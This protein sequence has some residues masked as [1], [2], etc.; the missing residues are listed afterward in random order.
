MTIA[1]PRAEHDAT[2]RL[3][4]LRARAPDWRSS[5]AAMPPGGIAVFQP[6]LHAGAARRVARALLEEA[7][8]LGG[9]QVLGFPGGDLLLG[10]HAAPGQR[11][12]QA[13]GRLL[14]Q[15][16]L[17]RPLPQ[18]VAEVSG[19]CEAAS[20]APAQ[21][22][23]SLAALEA[24]CAAW[25]LEAAARL[26][27]F[28]ESRV[29]GPVAQRLGPAPLGLGDPELEAMAR[30][31]LCRRILAALTHPAERGRLPMLRPGLRLILDLPRGGLPQL[32]PAMRA[33]HAG[34]S[35]T[36]EALAPVALLPLAA[37]HDPAGFARIAEGLRQAG[38]AVGLVASHAAALDWLELPDILWAIPAGEAPPT[39]WPGRLIALGH[40]APAWARAPGIWHEGGA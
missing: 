37:L 34:D 13:I 40:P 18:A 6:A 24:H 3:G 29:G 12:A 28:E 10:S 14:G 26:T 9:G 5:L 2:A 19:W 21:E 30:E 20:M 11:A 27:V 32:G 15:E 23:W 33:G 38:W 4:R 22:S 8:T 1:I 36:D 16:P 17:A 39:A 25:P 35:R 7:A 31:W